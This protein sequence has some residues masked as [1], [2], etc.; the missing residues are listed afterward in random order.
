VPTTS[1]HVSERPLRD[2]P[3]ILY[4]AGGVTGSLV[5]AEALRRGHRPIVAGRDR[6]IH[7]LGEA[8]GL[9]SVAVPLE[10]AAGL[11]ALLRRGSR[12][13]HVAGPYTV[14][15]AP[16]LDA[17]MA[18]RTPY[19]DVDGELGSFAGAL[20]RDAEARAARVPVLVG[21]GFGVTAAESV[22]MHVARRA[23]GARRLLLG[24]HSANAYKSAAA[25]LSKLDVLGRGGAWIQDGELK[26]GP[27]AHARFRAIVD[28]A[29]HT[30]V[31]APL[32]EALAAHRCTGIRD[33]VAGV[34]VSALV[35]PILRLA[36]P[37]IHGLLRRPRVRRFLERRVRRPAPA[38]QPAP[39]ERSFVWAQASGAEG[40]TTAVLSLGEGY[41]FAASAMVRSSERLSS[42]DG[43]GTWT[44]G[45]AFG[46]DFVLELDC[47][48]RQD[49]AD[50]PEGR[51]P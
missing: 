15:A 49:L 10:D 7:A 50:D 37:L 43:I 8:H 22:A 2:A 42:F 40:T 45:A 48:R 27:M 23:R 21:A 36:A 28:A 31:A 35:A 1:N 47:V 41:A 6:S 4:G 20:A 33:V 3:W 25:A 16:M 9:E 46:P 14:T 39:A 29:R 32:A 19:L 12:V 11:Q 18:T 38:A 30:F 5:L 44:P 51:I 17:C 13:L 34:P 26:L 24:V